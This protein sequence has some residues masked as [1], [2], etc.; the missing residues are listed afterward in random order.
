MVFRSEKSEVAKSTNMASSS[1]ER[2]Y[3]YRLSAVKFGKRENSFDELKQRPFPMIHE[4]LTLR[5]SSGE[6]IYD[7][8]LISLRQ[9]EL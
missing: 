5:N 3:H 9:S 1:T 7:L 6:R 4:E 2:W 8:S